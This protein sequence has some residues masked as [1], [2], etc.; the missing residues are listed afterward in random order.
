MPEEKKLDPKQEDQ[1]QP[2][3]KD[4][5]RHPKADKKG[6]RRGGR[7]Q[8][9]RGGNGG[10]GYNPKGGIPGAKHNDVAWYLSN[11]ALAKAVGSF[12]M[13]DPLGTVYHD[14]TRVLFTKGAR[15]YLVGN[16]TDIKYAVPGIAAVHFTPTLPVG[17]KTGSTF[18]NQLAMK[19]YIFVRHQNS[20]HANYEF[21]DLMQALYSVI[22]INGIYGTLT[23]LYGT[24]LKYSVLN[25]YKA[26]ALVKAQ[27]FDYK[28]IAKQMPDLY[29][30]IERLRCAFDS[31]P[32]PKKLP[33]ADRQL[34]MTANVF[35]DTDDE[36][37]PLWLF[38]Q[39]N[40]FGV[41][42]IDGKQ[43]AF[44]TPWTQ[45]NGSGEDG[46]ANFQDISDLVDALV[47]GMQSDEDYGIIFGDILKA[48]GRENCATLFQIPDTYEVTEI[49]DPNAN[50]QLRN[51]T[52]C[53]RTGLGATTLRISQEEETHMLRFTFQVSWAD[54]D[55]SR[56]AV[57]PGTNMMLAF[58]KKDIQ[59]GDMLVATRLCNKWHANTG[60]SSAG[61]YVEQC[62][63]EVL[64]EIEIFNFVAGSDDDITLQVT[65]FNGAYVLQVS[66]SAPETTIN[67]FVGYSR[68]LAE[69]YQFCHLP[70]VYLTALST[71]SSGDLVLPTML[72]GLFDMACFVSV[73]DRNL[74]SLNYTAAMSEFGFTDAAQ[75]G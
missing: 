43:D 69:Y 36:K 25:K 10:Q 9:H 7:H 62:G 17:P 33:I 46:R 66:N 68:F 11:P 70:R 74:D 35:K 31:Y 13:N 44:S 50:L 57:I 32:I 3:P 65:T 8:G 40:Y 26:E 63:T 49:L 53:Y 1:Q 24:M 59:P 19:I 18:I 30:V 23:R 73:D 34:W 52:L 4:D 38:V 61:M 2:S 28:D 5:Q 48:Y 37:S 56:S 12:S 55:N 22:S 71:T 75:V 60:A 29:A 64:T 20:G 14:D 6:Q 51:A 47:T 27:G 54:S 72:F 16:G 42:D 58:P 67:N 45:S 21:A 15:R 39:D 41:P